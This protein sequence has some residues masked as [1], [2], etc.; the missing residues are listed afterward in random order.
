MQLDNLGPKSIV[1]AR[2]GEKSKERVRVS[3][4][5]SKMGTFGVP[6]S[7]SGSKPP[8]IRISRSFHVETKTWNA[9]FH[10]KNGLC[11]WQ[12]S[13]SLYQKVFSFKQFLEVKILTFLFKLFSQVVQ[14]FE[15]LT[16]SSFVPKDSRIYIFEVCCSSPGVT[17]SPPPPAHW[18]LWLAY[19]ILIWVHSR[20]YYIV[21]RK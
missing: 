13:G 3:V 21:P 1:R 14:Y 8:F 16:L 9:Y 6:M 20:T 18:S 7:M 19:I 12:G 17:Q 4:L 11:S 10:T 15:A 5:I 2:R